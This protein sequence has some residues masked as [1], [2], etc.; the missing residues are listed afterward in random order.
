MDI[1]TIDLPDHKVLREPAKL[2]TFPLSEENKQFAN[3]LQEKMLAL[4]NAVGLA[5][6]QVGKSIQIIS[7]HIP[8]DV[9]KYR[10]NATSV[11]QP[12][13][14]INPTYQPL[15]DEGSYID[16][17]GCF[18]VPGYMGEVPRYNVIHYEAY[19]LSG[20]KIS[21]IARGFLARVLQHEIGHLNGQIF[22]DLLNN[23]CRFGT[24]DEMMKVRIEERE[25]LRSEKK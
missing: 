16:W 21:G 19:L 3:E 24:A 23:Q 11:V 12:T 25:K 7:F 13:I 15:E 22:K 14:L 9:M 1:V 4:D 8:S 2:V 18:S 5:A 10:K 20:E 17:E 6:T